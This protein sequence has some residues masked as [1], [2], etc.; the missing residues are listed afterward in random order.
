MAVDCDTVTFKPC[1]T[2]GA[3]YARNHEDASTSICWILLFIQLILALLFL[4]P[5]PSSCLSAWN[6]I[7]SCC[8][9]RR[10]RR[11]SE[12]HDEE[13]E[14][15]EKEKKKRR[16]RHRRL[17]A[18]MSKSSR[19]SRR[20]NGGGTMSS[21]SS[22]AQQNGDGRRSSA[23]IA[24]S[25]AEEDFLPNPTQQH[26]GAAA[27]T[28]VRFNEDPPL[29]NVENDDHEEEEED[30]M[31]SSPFVR[32]YRSEFNFLKRNDDPT[33]EYPCSYTD[34]Y[35]LLD[36]SPMSILRHT[37]RSFTEQKQFQKSLLNALGLAFLSSSL[38]SL[39]ILLFKYEDEL[40]AFCPYADRWFSVKH[41]VQ[42]SS[43]ALKT[44]IDAYK[45]LP[46]FLLLAY[47]AFLVERWRSFLVT[48]H[49]IQGSIHSIGELYLALKGLLMLCVYLVH[50]SAAES[51][52][53]MLLLTCFLALTPIL[54]H[55]L[56]CIKYIKPDHNRAFLWK[57][58]RC[59]CYKIIKEEV[60]Q[61]L[62]LLEFD[63]CLVL[64][65][66]FTVVV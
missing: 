1:F 66:L 19:S 5:P 47:T 16:D 62:S 7:S 30:I 17:R 21:S 25:D 34:V 12:D 33:I 31:F 46:L 44:A 56:P 41:V 43:E 9:G 6:Y 45:F 32:T 49:S 28:A 36:R 14:K 23:D 53:C 63:P 24:A 52:S 55:D 60:V 37:Y 57:Y 48:C 22:S 64:E 4:F 15:E 65:K 2:I 58:T 20:N 35:D 38:T 13:E 42:G 11:T 29:K 3:C 39:I 51:K 59:S 26:Y 10:Q 27:Q 8:H 40:E 18:A 61:D 54:N 50:L